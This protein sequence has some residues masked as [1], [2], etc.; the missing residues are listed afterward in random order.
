MVANMLNGAS[1]TRFKMNGNVYSLI[2]I[3]HGLALC[4]PY[5]NLMMKRPTLYKD[6]RKCKKGYRKMFRNIAI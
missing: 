4:K 1:D 3:L 6:A 2:F 5:M